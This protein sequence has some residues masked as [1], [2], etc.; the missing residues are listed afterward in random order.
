MVSRLVSVTKTVP[1]TVA[2]QSVEV[3]TKRTPAT[4]N[5][6][7]SPVSAAQASSGS[8]MAAASKKQVRPV[9]QRTNL[10]SVHSAKV[11]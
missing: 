1:A 8:T 3:T 6:A 5:S 2:F 9:P 4:V 11:Q 10:A 7:N